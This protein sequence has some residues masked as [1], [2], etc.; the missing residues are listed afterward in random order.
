MLVYRPKQFE[1]KLRSYAR[2]IRLDEK[3]AVQTYN[4]LA[5]DLLMSINWSYD[6]AGYHE[7]LGVISKVRQER[8]EEDSL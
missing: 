8:F 7:A 2:Y 4:H 5:Y 6:E 1:E 3:D